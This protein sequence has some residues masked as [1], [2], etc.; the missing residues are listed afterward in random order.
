[1][2][3]ENFEDNGD[4][5]EVWFGEDVQKR[6]MNFL[7]NKYPSLD[8]YQPYV[9]DVGTGNGAFLFKLAKKGF[10]LL[11]GIDYSEN[12]IKLASKIKAAASEEKDFEC[13]ELEYQNAFDLVD[14][15]KFDIIHDKGTFDVI[16]MNVDLDNMLYA[17]GIS[18]RLKKDG[19]FI[20]T[21]CNCTSSELDEIFSSV[22]EKVDE[23]KG[24][25]SFTFGG[26]TGYVVS[27]NVY[28]LC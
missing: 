5:G 21:S 9:L 24:Y 26:V 11:K 25:K 16:Y 2:E 15:G 3:I 23:I 17:K 8:S 18:H 20:I 10:K 14:G 22:F 4:D 19:L 6:T 1:M 28:R 12:S 27:T 7:V 13:I